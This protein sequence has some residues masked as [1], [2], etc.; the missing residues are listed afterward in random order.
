MIYTLLRLP[1]V[2]SRTGKSR[3][4]LYRDMEDALFPHPVSIGTNAVAWPEHEIQ[5]MNAAR[6]AGK[7]EGEIRGIVADLQSQRVTAA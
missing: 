2:L 6:I 5:A 7:S 1:E 4:A 3:S